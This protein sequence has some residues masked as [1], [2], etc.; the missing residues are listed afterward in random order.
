[1]IYEN[2]SEY[3]IDPEHEANSEDE[4]KLYELA[5]NVS[6]RTR[7]QTQIELAV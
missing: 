6:M 5:P 3:N 4:K 7:S 2:D 1:M